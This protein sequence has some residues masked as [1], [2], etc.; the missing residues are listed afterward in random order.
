MSFTKRHL[1]YVIDLNKGGTPDN[2]PPST[3]DNGSQELTIFDVR[4]VA[5]IQSV[6]GGDTAFGGRALLQIWGMKPADMAQLSTLG[7]DQARINKNKVTVFA[8]DE[9]NPD[10]PV[11]V[12]SG[13]IFVAHINYN[14]MPDVSLTLECYATIDQQTQMV[15]GT[16]VAG[17]GDV[18]TML[19]GICAA[20][21][22][23]VTFVNKGVSAQLANPASAGSPAQQIAD[24]C[25]SAGIPHTLQDDT[26][27]IWPKDTNVDGVVIETGPDK[28]MVGYPEY[29]Q[30][31]IDVTMEFNPDVQLGRQLQILPVNVSNPLPVPGVPGT[32]WINIV[33]H[34]L[35]S[36][37]PDGPWF[38]HASVSNIQIVGRS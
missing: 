37:M 21:N 26:L 27:T 29:T 11:Q 19:Q 5:S 38:T 24:I 20:C 34:E 31:G 30:I 9:D 6:I 7:F 14:A 33:E 36:E 8:Y 13:G 32:F 22:P 2:S 1:Q 12:F 16:S 35:S 23:P 4:S 3:F 17:S 15:P 18:A 25:T 10:N 28:G